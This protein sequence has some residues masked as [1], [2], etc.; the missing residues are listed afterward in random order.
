[1]LCGEVGMFDT[2]QS[3]LHMVQTQDR[4]YSEPVNCGVLSAVSSKNY[5][6]CNPNINSTKYGTI[7]TLSTLINVNKCSLGGSVKVCLM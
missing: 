7:N 2:L 5:Y 3:A 1:M 6:G 4:Y